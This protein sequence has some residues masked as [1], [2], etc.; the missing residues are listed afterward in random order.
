MVNTLHA[1]HCTA[2]LRCTLTVLH[3]CTPG[4]LPRLPLPQLLHIF[5]HTFYRARMPHLYHAHTVAQ[6]AHARTRHIAYRRLRR[7]HA[8]YLPPAPAYPT[9]THSAYTLPALR[10]IPQH[11]PP[12]LYRATA[13]ALRCLCPRFF[14]LPTV[15]YP[16]DA[17]AVSRRNGLRLLLPR[18]RVEQTA[19]PAACLHLHCLPSRCS[20]TP[21]TDYG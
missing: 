13:T 3:T 15:A 8:C 5:S 12:H 9:H 14:V 10:H 2:H 18:L 20:P 16:S 1:H 21:P 6:Y 4:H 19:L 17:S 7:M 11:A